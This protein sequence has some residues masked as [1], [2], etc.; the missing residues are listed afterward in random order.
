ME[1]VIE[2]KNLTKKV[3]GKPLVEEINLSI[4]KGEICGLIGPNGAG[5]TTIMKLLTGLLIPT[6]G[7]VKLNQLDV[8]KQRK[9]AMR[10]VGAIIESPIFFEFMTGR[11]MLLNLAR[12]HGLNK[13]ERQE[14]V[15]EALAIVGLGGRGDEKIR[16][17][18]LGMKQRLGIAQALL[19]N[20]EIV[21]LDEPANGLDPMGMRELREL[22]LQLNKE[23]NITFLLSSH[24][25]DELQKICSTLIIIKQGNVLFYGKQEEI[26]DKAE[27]NLEDIFIGMMS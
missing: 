27:N 14:K 12:L 23:R 6:S 9:E 26:Y 22:I 17:Y 1:K 4:A 20:P 21:I 18:S 11:G 5:K 19:G 8:H 3:K 10:S 13:Q 25:L 15:A 16:T 24:L 7:E 2:T